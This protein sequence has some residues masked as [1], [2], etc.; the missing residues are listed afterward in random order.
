MMTLGRPWPILRQGQLWSLMLLYGKKEKQLIFSETIVVYCIKVGRCSNLN[1]F[2]NLYEY[3]RS[4]SFIDLGPR[5]VSFNIFKL[6]FLRNRWA[7]WSRISVEPPWDGEQKVVQM[8]QVT[9]PRWLPCPYMVKTLK[10]LLPWNQKADDFETWYAA[11]SANILY[12]WWQCQIWSLLLLYGKKNQWIFQKL[13]YSMISKLVDAVWVNQISFPQSN[14]RSFEAKFHSK[15]PWDVRM[16]MCS[17]VPDHITKMASRPIYDEY[18][19]KSPSSEPRGRWPWNLVYSIGYSSTTKCVQ[20]MIL[21]SPWPFLWH[22]QICFLMLLHTSPVWNPHIK[23]R[24]NQLE[25]VQRTAA[26]WTCRSWRN[27]SHIGDMLNELEWPTLEDRREQA[28]LAFFHKIHSGTVAIER[29]T[30]LTPAPR[31]WQYTRYLT[32]SDALKTSFPRTIPVCNALLA[33][34]VSIERSSSLL[35]R[36]QSQRCA[37]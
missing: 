18:L 12:I 2:M 3:Q 37:F 20:M 21:D 9:R 1:E 16:K 29:N 31:L 27:T 25:K 30:Y 35:F 34:F 28:S 7:D 14:T 22:G 11:S 5:S 32:F 15:P 24:V 26:R 6:L 23:S 36:L 4:G 13:L 33:Y 19:E 10:H 17:D 8:F